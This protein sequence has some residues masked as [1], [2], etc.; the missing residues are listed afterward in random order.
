MRV[1]FFFLF[2]ASAGLNSDARASGFSCLL[3][4]LSHAE[5]PESKFSKSVTQ[6]LK[7]DHMK[8]YIGRLV[9]LEELKSFLGQD[10][11]E[12]GETILKQ[13][14]PDEY[15][16][17]LERRLK[18]PV[19][20]LELSTDEKKI[21]AGLDEIIQSVP[22]E[23]LDRNIT[24]LQSSFPEMINGRHHRTGIPNLLPSKLNFVRVYRGT[25]NIQSMEVSRSHRGSDLS[26]V[27]RG[28]EEFLTLREGSLHS[29]SADA[30]I[31]T[32]ISVSTNYNSAA[33]YGSYVKIYDLP[34]EMFD[35]LPSGDVAL[36]EKVVKHSIP[37]E[38][39]V[40]AM[41]KNMFKQALKVIPEHVFKS[42]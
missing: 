35:R 3:R 27:P 8:V 23:K 36:Y 21:I 9:N 40:F 41:S 37:D 20:L 5:T 34:A 29:G 26:N 13:N 11:I 19:E 39:L 6:L 18:L 4:F 33:S 28:D 30:G 16:E 7:L 12:L 42:R 32:G 14:V 10:R 24:A 2:F 1:L 31:D 17:L 15:L 22:R 38:Y 25:G